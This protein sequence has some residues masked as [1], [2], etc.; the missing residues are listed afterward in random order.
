MQIIENLF[1]TKSANIWDVMNVH[2]GIA[3]FKIPEYQRGYNWNEENVQRLLE[4]CFE[5]LCKFL[6]KEENQETYTY[7]GTIVVVEEDQT[8]TE[9][10]FDGTSLIVVDGQQRLITLSL[11]CCALTEALRKSEDGVDVLTVEQ[12]NWLKEE[13][14]WH[15]AQ[16]RTGIVGKLPSSQGSYTYPKIVRIED[17]GRRVRGTK[18]YNSPVAR[19]LYSHSD[20]KIGQSDVDQIGSEYKRL[21]ETYSYI[22]NQINS[23]YTENSERVSEWEHRPIPLNEIPISKYRSLLKK[24]NMIPSDDLASSISSLAAHPN[25]EGLLKLILF[26]SYLNHYVVL[27]QIETGDE[28]YAFDIFDSLNTT[29]EPLTALETFKPKV[30]QYENGIDGYADSESEEYL[31]EI[32]KNVDER[33]WH[34]D[35][36]ELLTSFALYLEGH[37]LP[38]SLSTQRTYLRQRFDGIESCKPALKRRFISAMSDMSRFRNLVWDSGSIRQIR[39]SDPTSEGMLQLCLRF[40]YDMKT[41]LALPILAR[42]WS[43]YQFSERFISAV[44]A[45]S[46]FIMLRRSVTGSTANIDSDFRSLMREPDGPEDSAW[47][48][49]RN[50]CNPIPHV[51]KLKEELRSFLKDGF[52][53]NDKESWVEQARKVPIANYSRPLCRLL[54]FSAS[55]GA[56]LDE[57]NIG[58]LT[59]VDA[60]PGAG[61]QY[62]DISTWV[63]SHYATVEHVAPVAGG[64]DWDNAIYDVSDPWRDTIGN[65]IL[66][67]Q[68]ENSSIG[69]ASWEKKKVFY[70]A[71]TAETKSEKEAFIARA[72][73]S[74]FRFSKRT[75]NLLKKGERLPMLDSISDVEKWDKGI[76]E[77]RGRNILDLAWDSVAIWL[78]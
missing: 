6:A 25:T 46:A 14:H 54:L 36:K 73:K 63:K 66:L 51:D 16:L 27:T 33:Q 39:V 75:K 34:K 72:E 62:L 4:D 37:R 35:T 53:V 29:G 12:R 31:D 57:Q 2:G 22:K 24:V 5:G 47:C 70:S 40:I 1:R 49:G 55:H 64:P 65:L 15:V 13:T 58:T 56:M 45:V 41:S 52:K 28:D 21:Q 71:L 30:V 43:D 76:I 60:V 61:L 23:I 26:S 50:F 44:F 32:Y 67:P 10:T 78:Y 9:E 48:V 69:N 38:G 68:K 19:F 74:G 18:G 3:G 7:L 77:K 20:E 11:L 17:R 8:S 59:R 42:Y